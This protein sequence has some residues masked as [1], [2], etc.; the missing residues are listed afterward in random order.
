MDGMMP[1]MHGWGVL[2]TVLVLALLITIVVL[3]VRRQP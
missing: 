1:M 2:V 3:L